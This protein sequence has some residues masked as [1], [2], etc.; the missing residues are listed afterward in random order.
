[1]NL[2]FLETNCYS[3]SHW[4]LF[5]IQQETTI[6]SLISEVSRVPWTSWLLWKLKVYNNFR[7]YAAPCKIKLIR[8]F[9]TIYASIVKLLSAFPIWLCRPRTQRVYT[10]TGAHPIQNICPYRAYHTEICTCMLM[11]KPQGE[12]QE[13]EGAFKVFISTLTLWK[14]EKQNKSII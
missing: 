1:M 7:N 4:I 9:F 6:W 12:V 14:I 13:N 10:A 11:H 8:N 3:A 2:T 5:K